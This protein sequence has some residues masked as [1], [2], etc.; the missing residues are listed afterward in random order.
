MFETL[1]GQGIGFGSASQ[2]LSCE[3]RIVMFR[4]F[5]FERVEQV[6]IDLN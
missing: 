4:Y 5:E 2:C 3:R 6:E 1:R